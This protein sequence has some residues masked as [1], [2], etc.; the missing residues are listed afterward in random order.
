PTVVMGDLN[1][2]PDSSSLKL[3]LCR[4]RTVLRDAVLEGLEK[5]ENK[6]D[7]KYFTFHLFKGKSAERGSVLDYILVSSDIGVLNA[8]PVEETVDGVFPSDHFPIRAE[9]TY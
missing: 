4:G 9:L 3:L 5:L 6:L 2:L 1:T 7:G 8:S